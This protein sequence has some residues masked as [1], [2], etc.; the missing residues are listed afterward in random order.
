[1][2][3]VELSFGKFKCPRTSFS[4]LYTFNHVWSVI[5]GSKVTSVLST[6]LQISHW[7]SASTKTCKRGYSVWFSVQSESL[8]LL[9]V[10]HP[11]WRQEKR[12]HTLAKGY[13]L[14]FSIRWPHSFLIKV[15]CQN[16][17]S[18]QFRVA[19]VPAVK[20]KSGNVVLS[21]DEQ[22]CF[23][24]LLGSMQQSL[25]KTWRCCEEIQ[26]RAGC[27]FYDWNEDGWRLG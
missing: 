8:E 17:I 5:R 7:A 6:W 1:M 22:M 11:E 25:S 12:Q 19:R 15:R 24:E 14:N 13:L 4:L 2:P 10:S 21:F 3:Q 27:S 23:N 9:T 20:T 16:S 18:R 26:S